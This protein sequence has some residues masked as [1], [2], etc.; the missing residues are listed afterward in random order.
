M[1]NPTITENTLYRDRLVI[2]AVLIVI[3]AASWAY[4]LVQ[5]SF[6]DMTGIQTMQGM[7]MGDM[8]VSGNHM[9]AQETTMP[10]MD[11]S[12]KSITFGQLVAVGFLA[13]MWIIMMIGMMVPSTTGMVLAFSG[14]NKKR[15]DAGLPFV[16][17][18]IF[19]SGY[20]A[21]WAAFGIA[22]SLLQFLLQQTGL[23]QPMSALNDNKLVAFIYLAAG[24]FQ[25]SAFK[26]M[27]L[28]HCRSPM[29][30]IMNHWKEGQVGAF[31]MGWAHGLYC[32]G[33][34][35]LLMALMFAVGTMNIHVMAALTL[36]FLIEKAAPRADLLARAVGAG[37]IIYA[38]WLLIGGF[39]GVFS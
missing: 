39:L 21:L 18:L 5:S 10:N 22:C 35:W 3:C 30:Y 12:M 34:C 17:T 7:H 16:S 14:I 37:L 1:S 26:Q 32:V 6:L 25:F 9:V 11:R 36:Y 38:I 29:A 27:C 31:T 15:R 4:L 19:V 8:A 28:N 2:F 33:C 20:L 13:V 24:L 23:M